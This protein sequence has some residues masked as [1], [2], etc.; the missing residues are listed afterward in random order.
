MAPVS[1]DSFVR[2]IVP[3]PKRNLDDWTP[4][5]AYLADLYSKLN[6]VHLQLQGDS[7]NSVET[8]SVLAGFLATTGLMK[9]RIGRRDFSLFPSLQSLPCDDEDVPW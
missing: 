1:A 7:L 9:Q 4:D 8:K 6:A 5:M 3:V 2:S